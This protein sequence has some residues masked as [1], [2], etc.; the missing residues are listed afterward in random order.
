MEENKNLF[1]Y[2]KTQK[3]DDFEKSLNSSIDLNIK[4]EHS[5][6]L[7][8]YIILYNNIKILKKLLEYDI[9]LD[10]LDNEGRSILYLPIKYG[11]IDIIKLLLEVEEKKI[12]ISILNVKDA[13]N[14]F[15]LHYALFFKNIEIFNILG[16]KSNFYI[17][18]KNK[19][20]LLHI[21]TK[22]KNIEFIKKPIKSGINI[23]LTNNNNETPLHI[24]CIYDLNNFIELF[25]NLNC[26]INIREK[27]GGLTPIMLCIL[28]G[29]N[30]GF[31]LFIKRKNELNI[32]IQDYEG[33]TSL[34]LA[35]IDNNYDIIN[36][37]INLNIS[38]EKNISLNLNICN[39]E[40]NTP[41]HI[42]LSKIFYDNINI[43]NYN[44]EY[45]LINTNLNI[46]NNDG[47]TC[48]H[49]IIVTKLYRTYIDVL[50]NKK[51]NLFILD[52]KNKTAYELL[53]DKKKTE[54]IDLVLQ[55]LI[56]SYL[57]LLKK[58]DSEIWTIDWEK[59]CS[60][61]DANKDK[62]FKQIKT[63]IIENSISIPIKKKYYC[64][65][66]ENP[67]KNTITTFTGIILD[68]ITCYIVLQKN[69]PNLLTSITSD[70]VI[71]QNVE[72]YYKKLGIT[73][74]LSGDYLNFEL[75]WIFH[76]ELWPTNIENSINIFIKSD[77]NIFAIPIGIDLENGSHANIIIIDKEF[78]TIER[79]E[80]NG[81]EEPI[82]FNYNKNLLDFKIK[83]YLEKFFPDY[84]YLEPQ[85]FLPN[86]GFQSL[87]MIEN[88]KMKKIGDPG[89]F[90]V[91]WCLWY[92][93]QR[94]KFNVHPKFLALKLIIKI[95]SKNISF[96]N[97]IRS[98]VNELLNQGRDPI[99]H[100]LNID[101]NDIINENIDEIQIKNLE[102]LITAEIS[103]L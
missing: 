69:Y 62:C 86:I 20:S 60:K 95:K 42:I 101:I 92:L 66:I 52:K 85:E 5:N 79:F 67:K 12:G 70:F 51:N 50:S 10:W 38:S 18:D 84:E 61:P 31:N 82:N 78:K 55:I 44:I 93:E 81:G 13:Y 74:E 37:I 87:E 96:K 24:S 25:I 33:N 72:Q 35:I 63:H 32:N 68:I 7:I 90:C 56:N 1:I 27:A 53:V 83:I 76:K 77:K 21:I 59:I 65:E 14:N 97:L 94:I 3:W 40:G 48:W 41:L 47:E 57:N 34:H 23:N 30:D 36:K 43:S 29:N 73:K 4:D 17:F 39:L 22:N 16:E 8:Q 9:E 99:L 54:D 103:K 19:N 64:I 98:Y 15:P 28:N 91:G 2:L 80:P 49:Y 6:Y 58:K 88:K 75:F 102:K 26:D 46:Q 45:F 71:N 89:G 100:E 11:Y